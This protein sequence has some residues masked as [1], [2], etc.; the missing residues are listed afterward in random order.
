MSRIK[1][2]N[3]AP[4]MLVRSFLHASGF[5]FVLHDKRLP[6]KPDIVLPKYRTVIFVQGCFW[7]MHEGCTKSNLPADNHEFWV[8][9][10]NG[11]RERDMINQKL[12]TEKGWKVLVIWTCELLKAKRDSVL[13]KLAAEIKGSVIT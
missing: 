13:S 9:K 6:G 10:L 2:R 8:K 4:E 3:T 7:H 5:R 12:L 1:G 11:N